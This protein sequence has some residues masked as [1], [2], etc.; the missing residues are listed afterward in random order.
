M[1]IS[2]FICVFFNF[3][4]LVINVEDKKSKIMSLFV[5]VLMFGYLLKR[6]KYKG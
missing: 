5:A 4:L 3:M 6:D 1:I 2:N